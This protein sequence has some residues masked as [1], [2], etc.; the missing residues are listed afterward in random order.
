MKKLLFILLLIFNFSLF[1]QVEMKY[2]ANAENLPHWV[3]LMYAENL[4][5][6]AVIAAYRNYYNNNKLVKNKHTQYYKRW[7]R[8]LSRTTAPIKNRPKSKSSNQFYFFSLNL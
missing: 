1:A 4:D 5:E 3:Q 8:N 2:N 7:V 6:G